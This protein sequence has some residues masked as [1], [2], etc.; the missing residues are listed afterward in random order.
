MNFVA[1]QSVGL[2]NRSNDAKGC[3][4]THI[5]NILIREKV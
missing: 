4:D 2:K 1:L 3:F 5:I